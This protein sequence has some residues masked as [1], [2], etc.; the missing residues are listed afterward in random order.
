MDKN[1][2]GWVNGEPVYSAD[3][4]VFKKRGFGAI[5][6]DAEL[7]KFAEKASWGWQSA[8][9]KHS[10]VSF[11]LSDYAL[12]EPFR[13]LTK[14]EFNR[15]KELQAQARKEAEEADKAREWKY[16]RTIYWADNSIEEI[17]QDKDGIEK[18]V[19]VTG[20]HGDVCY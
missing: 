18:S 1:I 3:E 15:L 9:H 19:M 7:L 20:P 2:Y 5:T 8:G 16:V 13:S 12:A 17:W 14:A 6:D 4:F 11:Y 10:F